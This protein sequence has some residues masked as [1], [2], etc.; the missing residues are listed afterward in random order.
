MYDPA[1]DLSSVKIKNPWQFGSRSLTSGP[2]LQEQILFDILT[3]SCFF[4]MQYLPDSILNHYQLII[5]PSYSFSM[6]HVLY[7]F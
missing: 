7:L 4:G 2:T 3:F 1:V 5:Q 6:V